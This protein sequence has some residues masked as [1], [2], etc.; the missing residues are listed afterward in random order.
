MRIAALALAALTPQYMHIMSSVSNDALGALAG[1]LLF[2]LTVRATTMRS[3][4]LTIYFNSAR[5]YPAI[6]HQV[7]CASCQRSVAGDHRMDLDIPPAQK[8]MAVI[9]GLGSSIGH[10]S[11][12]FNVSRNNTNRFK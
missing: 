9:C 3:N 6:N 5:H 1:A 8:K 11:S 2:Y 4:L 12:L 7:D 10:G